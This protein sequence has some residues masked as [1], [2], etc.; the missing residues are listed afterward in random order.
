[1]YVDKLG[2]NWPIICSDCLKTAND[3]GQLYPVN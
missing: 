3:E 2:M 1:M